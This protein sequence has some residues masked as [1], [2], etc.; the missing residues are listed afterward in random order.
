MPAAN[1]REGT[2]GLKTLHGGEGFTE[3]PTACGA[4]DDL[5]RSDPGRVTRFRTPAIRICHPDADARSPRAVKA[6]HPSASQHVATRHHMSC[7]SIR[8]GR[9]P[10]RLVLTR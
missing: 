3:Y 10:G 1:L 5:A 6:L 2:Q 8:R 9:V 7:A 4:H